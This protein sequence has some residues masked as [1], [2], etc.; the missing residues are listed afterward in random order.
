VIEL[1]TALASLPVRPK[2][3]IVFMTYYGEEQGLVGSRHYA[4]NPVFPITKT[5]ANINL[6]QVGR[7]DDGDDPRPASATVT[8]IDYSDVGEVLRAAGAQQGIRVYKHERNSDAYF[9][10]SD[11]RALADRGVPAHTLATSFQFPDAHQVGDHADKIDYDNM[12]H[13]N[14]AIA[15]AILMIANNPR[16]PRW[17]PDQPKAAR[18]LTAWQTERGNEGSPSGNSASGAP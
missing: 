15:L 11:N 2:R 14:R 13:V 5:I 8:G 4:T 1:A 16:E 10:R 17:N 3:S 12:A 6:E 18:Y 9:S 7:T